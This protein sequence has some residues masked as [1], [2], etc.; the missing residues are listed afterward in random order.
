[1]STCDMIYISEREYHKMKHSIHICIYMYIY[2]YIH[3]HT[4]IQIRII[5]NRRHM[6]NEICTHI[7]HIMHNTHA[8]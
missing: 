4:F 3:T 2:I 5:Y 7:V 1:M 8:T 6:T